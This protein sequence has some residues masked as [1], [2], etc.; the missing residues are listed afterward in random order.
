MTLATESFPP[1][2]APPDRRL[3][4]LPVPSLTR[5]PI[6]GRSWDSIPTIFSFLLR[7]KNAAGEWVWL[8]REETKR[9]HELL[10]EDLS[11]VSSGSNRALAALRCQVGQ[12]VACGT[13]DGIPVSALRIC[14]SSRLV[15]D[16][17]AENGR[18][19]HAIFA[20]A[21]A[22]LN[23]AQWVASLPL[24]QSSSCLRAA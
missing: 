10:R 11:N 1:P 4:S 22:V 8:D 12:P 7:R 20:D 14:A 5:A 18:G 2:S 13:R 19:S 3:P 17:L 6:A 21:F 23:K 9:V 15:V 16:A 24:T